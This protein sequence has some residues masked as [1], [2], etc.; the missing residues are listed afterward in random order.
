MTKKA[1]RPVRFT[2]DNVQRVRQ[3][4]AEGNSRMSEHFSRT[5]KRAPTRFMNK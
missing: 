4:A 1:K 3:M 5:A 2:P